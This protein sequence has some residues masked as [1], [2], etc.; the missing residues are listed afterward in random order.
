MSMGYKLTGSNASYS[1]PGTD[2]AHNVGSMLSNT[3]GEKSLALLSLDDD[4]V[5]AGASAGEVQKLVDA[6][7]AAGFGGLMADYEPKGPTAGMAVKYAAMLKAIAAPMQSAGLLMGMDISSWGILGAN[8]F[9][10]YADVG[11]D[12]YMSMAST[13]FGTNVTKNEEFL[14]QE[15]AAGMGGGRVCRQENMPSS[16]VR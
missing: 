3:F 11:L 13:Y 14:K 16:S 6:V 1:G 5:R 10:T 8:D 9:K 15:I 2:Y 12:I 7:N 4:A